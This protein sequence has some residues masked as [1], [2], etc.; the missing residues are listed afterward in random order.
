MKSLLLV[1]ALAG[2]SFTGAAFGH[3]TA[4]ARSTVS[5]T[6]VP[7]KVVNPTGLPLQF[8]GADIRVEFKLDAAG[9]PRDI[10]V[11]AV[12]DSVLK[13]Q[14]VEAFRQ[15]RFEP[16]VTDPAAANHRFI[17]PLHLRPEV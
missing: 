17:L 3:D 9:Q 5:P 4:A 8:A 15:W 1:A 11:L 2:V 6:P 12:Q 7:V 13:R 14:I 16:G 10:R